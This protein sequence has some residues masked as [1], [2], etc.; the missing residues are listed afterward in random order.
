MPETLIKHCL[1]DK[2]VDIGVKGPEDTSMRVHAACVT[3]WT[4]NE[5]VNM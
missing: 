2:Q 3:E 4:Q 5:F 1:R